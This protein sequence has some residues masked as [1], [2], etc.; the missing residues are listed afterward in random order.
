MVLLVQELSLLY[1]S[2]SSL[3]TSLSSSLYQSVVLSIPVMRKRCHRKCVSRSVS[4]CPVGEG[5]E[6]EE[7]GQ[8]FRVMTTL[9]PAYAQNRFSMDTLKGR[10][11]SGHSTI[12]AVR[13][14]SL[15]AVSL[16]CHEF[17]CSNFALHG[18]NLQLY[19]RGYLV[20]E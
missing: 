2:L 5:G 10:T 20:L 1:T 6:G 9:S 14:R 12:A 4:G 18:F 11:I 17:G 19:R 3:Y 7:D 8:D 15:S 16:P 13:F